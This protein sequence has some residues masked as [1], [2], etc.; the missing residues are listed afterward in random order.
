[1]VGPIILAGQLSDPLKFESKANIYAIQANY[2]FHDWML[3][4][5]NKELW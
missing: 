5:I 1:M 4:F 2:D 3:G